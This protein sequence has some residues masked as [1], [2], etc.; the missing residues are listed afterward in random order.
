M[1]ETLVTIFLGLLMLVGLAGA[2]IPVLPDVVLIWAAALGYGFLSGWESGGIWLFVLIT[3]LGLIG[4]VMD[5]WM[6]GLGAR[7]GGASVKALV[8]GGL[9]GLVGM[10]FFT[11][12]GGVVL[13]LVGMFYVEYQRLDDAEEAMRGILGLGLGY[14]ASMGVKLIIG[15]G[16]IAAWLIWVFKV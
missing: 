9:L 5:I 15:L 2:I 10:I 6:S 16:M 11:P 8:V 12:I 13:L 1:L 7:K 3:L 4:M 14:G